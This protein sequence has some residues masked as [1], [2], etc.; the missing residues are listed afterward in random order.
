MRQMASPQKT[1]LEVEEAATVATGGVAYI[2]CVMFAHL[3]TYP[4]ILHNSFMIEVFSSFPRI[5]QVQDVQVA[6]P[7]NDT[8]PEDVINQ[9]TPIAPP[10]A[11]PSPYLDAHERRLKYQKVPPKGSETE[12]FESPTAVPTTAEAEAPV[13]PDNTEM[14]AEENDEEEASEVLQGGIEMKQN[15]WG[16]S[17]LDRITNRLKTH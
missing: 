7:E 4:C 5:G 9:K 6:A 10:A 8:Q 16:M 3:G 13:D 15:T 17:C 12:H 2:A 14:P 1:E 11:T